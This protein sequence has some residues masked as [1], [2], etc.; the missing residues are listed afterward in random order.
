MFF[1]F[2]KRPT[3]ME[4]FC[5]FGLSKTINYTFINLNII[6]QQLHIQTWDIR[7]GKSKDILK[8]VE[9]KNYQNHSILSLQTI[10]VQ[11]TLLQTA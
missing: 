8:V 4:T 10:P 2:Q 1:P 3:N 6:V 7:T 9:R 5:Y 11:T